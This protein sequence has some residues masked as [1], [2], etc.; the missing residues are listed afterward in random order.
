MNACVLKD[1]QLAM[2]INASFAISAIA[3][4]VIS[5]I[6]V[7]AVF[8]VSLKW[9]TLANAQLEGPSAYY[10]THVSNAM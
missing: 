8:Q 1:F 2:T 10:L 5:K 4:N 6:F 3:K 7:R 9:E